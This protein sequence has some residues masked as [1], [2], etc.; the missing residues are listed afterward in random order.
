MFRQLLR[1]RYLCA[2][3]SPLSTELGA[4][5]RQLTF[6]SKHLGVK[7]LDLLIGTWADINVPKLSTT[8]LL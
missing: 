5:R 6:R 2:T 8:E 1:V 7:E 3:D 4:L